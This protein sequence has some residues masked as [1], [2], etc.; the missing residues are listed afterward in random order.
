[1]PLND[2]VSIPATTDDDVRRAAALIGLPRDAFH[3]PD[4]N[5]PRAEL[6]K[7]MCS[8]DVAACPGSG[9]TTLLVAKLAILAD[10]WPYR[11]RG[12]CVLSHTNAARH[13]I[14]TR[15]GNSSTGQR[16]LSYPHFIGTIHA[17]VDQFLAVPWLRSVG[18]PVTMID[19][20]ICELKR[21]KR[22][23]NKYRHALTQRYIDHTGLRIIDTSFRV[24]KKNGEFPFAE[25][26][27]TYKA[28]VNACEEVARAG[29][30]CY[31]DMFIWAADLVAQVEN[32]PTVVQDRFP[33]L[34]VDEAQDNSEEQ[35]A[36]LNRIFSISGSSVV[37]QRFGDASQAIYNFTG[38]KGATT[39]QFPRGEIKSVPDS[40]RFGPTIAKLS[41]PLGVQQHDGGLRGRGPRRICVESSASERPPT[42]FLFDDSTV[43]NVLTRYAELL[44]E[45]FSPEELACG[46]FAAVGQVH[47]D[48]GNDSRPRHVG[49]YWPEYDPETGKSDP[50]PH[51]FVQYIRAGQAMAAQSGSTHQVVEKI[52]E[53][54]LRLASM[55]DT[56]PK[57]RARRRRH[58]YV[59]ELLNEHDDDGELYH[60]I[61]D[62][63]ALRKEPLNKNAWE[64]CLSESV[65]R[66]GEAITGEKLSNTDADAFLAWDDTAVESSSEGEPESRRDNIYRHPA[67]DP[68][69]QI[70][71]GSIHSVKGQTHTA[72]LILETFWNEHNLDKLKEWILG[73]HSGWNSGDG[74]RQQV[75]LKLHYVAMTRP[76]HLLCLA[77]KKSTFSAS[78]GQLDTECITK[79]TQRGWQIKE[80]Q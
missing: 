47:N 50:K 48:T 62:S 20:E 23:P 1:M 21:W 28:A 24:S 54:I 15:L 40:H 75:R 14:E 72:T 45:T 76:T 44:I 35:S 64:S 42:I 5:D 22:M 77:M 6:L 33:I 46:H 66:V 26:T 67:A 43:M 78:D 61:L 18:Y 16:L 13:E 29:F 52:A 8:I 49:H 80:I 73:D 4:G 65:R 19:S 55:A 58:R 56:A 12:I 37:R 9:K 32:I 69:V 3:G 31:D 36:I 60:S 10:K 30:H 17:F 68:K 70:K 38:A 63:F 39:D 27:D 79:L 53:A 59:V 51:T 2:Q 34:F 7:C 74:K 57:L 71:V 25:T 11:T 41:E